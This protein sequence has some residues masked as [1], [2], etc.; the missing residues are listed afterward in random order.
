MVI[1]LSQE[2]RVSVSDSAEYG[3]SGPNLSARLPVFG[4][5]RGRTFLSLLRPQEGVPV[6]DGGSPQ[7]VGAGGDA[8]LAAKQRDFS[9]AAQ[10]AAAAADAGLA[11]AKQRDFTAAA[12][13]AAADG[14]GGLAGAK[15]RDFAAAAQCIAADGAGGLAAEHGHVVATTGVHVE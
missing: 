4:P 1:L 11:A 8:G 2:N 13:C 15:Q 3:A 14:A 10:R 7:L 12:R 6:A 9:A 5:F